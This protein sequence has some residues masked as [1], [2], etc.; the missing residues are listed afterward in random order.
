MANTGWITPTKEVIEC[1]T[2]GHIEVIRDTPSLKRFVPDFDKEWESLERIE[3]DC[4]ERIDEDEHPE[5]HIYEMAESDFR[6]DV[7]KRLMDAGC[8]R[9]YENNFEGTRDAVANLREFCLSLNDRA[10]FEL[11]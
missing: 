4:Q 8:I 11:R 7:W 5:W 6:A 9:F 10:E 1:D 2:Y 3:Q